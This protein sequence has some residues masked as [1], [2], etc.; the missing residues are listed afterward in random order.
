MKTQ[1]DDSGHVI[2]AE[3][4]LDGVYG[5]AAAVTPDAFAPVACGTACFGGAV[6]LFAVAVAHHADYI[7]G[8][9]SFDSKNGSGAVAGMSAVA[10][11][12]ADCAA[13]A[14]DCTADDN[15]ALDCLT[16][17]SCAPLVLLGTSSAPADFGS[18]LLPLYDVGW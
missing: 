6:K 3:I 9:L 16:S 7:V 1:Q 13:A 5:K 17:Q 18:P 2:G 10:A 15:H 11:V 4:L 8:N 14:A 12:A